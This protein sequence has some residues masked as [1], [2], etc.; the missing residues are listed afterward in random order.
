MC[1]HHCLRDTYYCG[2]HKGHNKYHYY[3]WDLKTDTLIERSDCSKE[4]RQ[5]LNAMSKESAFSVETTEYYILFRINGHRTD[6]TVCVWYMDGPKWMMVLTPVSPKRTKEYIRDLPQNFEL[7]AEWGGFVRVTV[8]N[9]NEDPQLLANLI[10]NSR[11][12]D[13]VASA[14]VFERLERQHAKSQKLLPIHM[15]GCNEKILTALRPAPRTKIPV[16][17]KLVAPN[18]SVF[19]CSD[20]TAPQSVTSKSM[21]IIA[22]PGVAGRGK[23][24]AATTWEESQLLALTECTTE[25]PVIGYYHNMRGMEVTDKTTVCK[26]VAEGFEDVFRTHGDNPSSFGKVVLHLVLDEV[27]PHQELIHWLV[28]EAGTENAELKGIIVSHLEGWCKTKPGMESD[29]NVVLV[30]SLVG[31]GVDFSNTTPTGTLPPNYLT[32]ES[33]TEKMNDPLPLR[34]FMD[35]VHRAMDEVGTKRLDADFSKKIASGGS[36]LSPLLTNARCALIAGDEAGRLLRFY[37]K[38]G[39]ADSDF[40]VQYLNSHAGG[41]ATRVSLEYIKT[42]AW[43]KLSISEFDRLASYLLSL[44]VTQPHGFHVVPDDVVKK[45]CCELGAVQDTLTWESRMTLSAR[46]Y[47]KTLNGRKLKN[48]EFYNLWNGVTIS[49]ETRARINKKIDCALSDYQSI[50]DLEEKF[51]STLTIDE[52]QQEINKK[53]CVNE[54]FKLSLKH[55][56]AAMLV[57]EEVA[58]AEFIDRMLQIRSRLLKYGGVEEIGDEERI[59]LEHATMHAR[60]FAEEKFASKPPQKYPNVLSIGD[61]YVTLTRALAA[62][63][64]PCLPSPTS[65]GDVPHIEGIRFVIPPAVVTAVLLVVVSRRFDRGIFGEIRDTPATAYENVA[66][67]IIWGTFEALRLHQLSLN[68]RTPFVK[69]PALLAFPSL[70][71]HFPTEAGEELICFKWRVDSPN[72]TVKLLTPAEGKNT[73]ERAEQVVEHLQK[74][75]CGVVLA[76]AGASVPQNDLT[77]HN[78]GVRMG[79]EFKSFDGVVELKVLRHRAFQMGFD[80]IH[81]TAPLEGLV[82]RDGGVFASCES[83]NFHTT[84]LSPGKAVTFLISPRGGRA[85]EGGKFETLQ[86][87]RLLKE[88]CPGK[89]VESCLTEFMVLCG[90]GNTSLIS[91][92]SF[93]FRDRCK[94]TAGKVDSLEF[95]KGGDSRCKV[96]SLQLGVH[97]FIQRSTWNPKEVVVEV[98]VVSNTQ[99][100]FESK[101]KSGKTVITATKATNYKLEVTDGRVVK[102]PTTTTASAT[103]SSS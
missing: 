83:V 62:Q 1:S 12:E 43:E 52:N 15:M 85:N 21:L 29:V 17:F 19:F 18:G 13:S 58:K 10:H 92:N 16:P 22:Y 99:Y 7:R 51:R 28:A 37:L 38:N 40:A 78:Y 23:S 60:V 68:P 98:P 59:C 3:P 61:E 66:S 20:D 75:S 57:A 55:V 41:I 26:E 88:S 87:E 35:A 50:A 5:Q 34:L 89:T 49:S 4:V 9:L 27:G 91:E 31:M 64:F 36:L 70:A 80:N 25:T 77:V 95:V 67:T 69:V 101:T 39:D 103:L 74:D 65:D 71:K 42:D 54:L 97:E 33:E 96:L 30:V 73:Y 24:F 76:M 84:E 53:R 47:V 56:Q 94:P 8:T 32:F 86:T 48:D 2:Q 93:E 11:K 45:L 81:C 72:Q 14:A 82:V 46:T 102:Q 63:A 44:S 6:E 79:I 90:P 100:V